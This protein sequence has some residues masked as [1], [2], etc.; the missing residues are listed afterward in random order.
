MAAKR[1]QPIMPR[2]DPIFGWSP[3]II[4]D[5]NDNDHDDNSIA[6]NNIDNESNNIHP[7]FFIEPSNASGNIVS[8]DEQSIWTTKSDA[9]N[10]SSSSPLSFHDNDDDDLISISDFFKLPIHHT[11]NRPPSSKMKTLPTQMYPSS[12]IM[13]TMIYQSPMHHLLIAAIF[14]IIWES[15]KTNKII[16]VP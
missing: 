10:S 7:Q 3:G 13:T 8:D 6:A 16:L 12:T 15:M 5:I 4:V 9:S 2:R 11:I 14:H 1:G